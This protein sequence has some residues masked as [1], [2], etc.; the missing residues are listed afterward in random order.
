MK[1]I[2]LFILAFILASAAVNAQL[3][4][5]SQTTI[6]RCGTMQH[7]QW[8]QQQDP[9]LQQKMEQEENKFN[10][11]IATH[12]NELKNN[13]T[14]YTIPVV[15]HVVYNG[16]YGY[17]SPTR[18]NEQ[19]TQT[20]ADWSGS[21]VTSIPPFPDSLIADAGITFCLAVIDPSGNPT[22]GIDYKTTTKTSFTTNDGVKS[23]STGGAAAWDPTK[24]L[25][26]WVCSLGSS[27]CGYAQFPTS[28]VNSTFGVVIHYQF[29]GLTGATPP[30]NLG[31]TTSH[32]LAHCFNLY[33]LWGDDGGA[34]TG[35][36]Y[37]V[38]TPNQADA[39]YG[40]HSGCLTDAC[41]P[42]CPGIMYMNF[43]DYSDDIDY[44]NF[45]PDQVVRMQ[46]CIATY[47]M[48]VA[49]NAATACN[50]QAPCTSYFNL[51][52]DTTTLHHYF[53]VNMAYSVHPMTYL[54]DWGDGTFDSI[55]YP[56]HT[57]DTAGYYDICLTIADSSGCT[58]TYC[59]S[60]Y[61]VQKS[62]NTVISVDV[63]PEIITGLNDQSEMS[64]CLIFPNPAC[65]KV[66]VKF[67]T[68]L[69]NKNNI[70]SIYDVKGQLLDQKKVNTLQTEINIA[71]LSK[72]VYILMVG[73][74]SKVEV[75][76]FI[77][78]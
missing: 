62:G 28:G 77:K 68:P 56:S 42:A 24:Y 59:D 8:M 55:A 41:T 26:I 71:D 27:L 60:A 66:F 33:H 2:T 63:I 69:A 3:E 16:T 14:S 40:D 23:T 13:K 31:G 30:Y 35:S 32:E 9:A 17:V 21:G 12:A 7:L 49:N 76:R 52:P 72:G 22:T 50:V 45:T 54:W 74:D 37:C 11:Y 44:S 20:N 70:I 1:K 61:Y 18:V 29:F 4:K 67:I 53:A 39:S 47:L 46:A 15:V 48:S 36:D 25:N 65:E 19:L 38:D 34:C 58:S 5:Q 57:F 6:D 43:M 73:N 75:F 64:S 78:K 51:Y 10:D